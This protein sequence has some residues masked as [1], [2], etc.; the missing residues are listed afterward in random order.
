MVVNPYLTFIG[1]SNVQFEFAINE[2]HGDSVA[3]ALSEIIA[4]YDT[5][6]NIVILEP[7]CLLAELELFTYEQI[8]NICKQVADTFGIHGTDWHVFTVE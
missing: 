6:N 7:D 4:E 1:I 3:N 2:L 5:E 8:R